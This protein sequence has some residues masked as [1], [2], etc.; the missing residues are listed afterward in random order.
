MPAGSAA[1][2]LGAAVLLQL[3]ELLE[4]IELLAET[5]DGRGSS[6]TTG[7]S[8][9]QSALLGTAAREGSLALVAGRCDVW[10]GSLMNPPQL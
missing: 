4:L 2:Q 3:I 5:R 1:R 10:L 6:R 7:G 8:Q 9:V